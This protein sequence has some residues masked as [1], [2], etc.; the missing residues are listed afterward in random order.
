[1]NISES[2]ELGGGETVTFVG[3]G[4][5]TSTM[6]RLASEFSFFGLSIV[7]TTTKIFEWEGKKADF[8]LI[9]EDIE[10][11]EN[12][13]SALSE[14]KIVTIASGKSKDEKLIGVEPEFADEINAQISPDILV[15]EGDGASKKSFKAPAD[16]EPVIPASSDLIVPIVGIDVVGETLNSE[17]VHRPKKV[18][19]ISHFEIGDTVTPE[20]IGQVVGHEKGGRKNVPS[21]ASLIPLL[22]KVDDESKEIAEEVAKKILSYTRQI[23]KVALGC[24]IRENPIIKIIER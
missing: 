23:D 9:S 15:I 21:D 18:C 19:E 14:G 5:K 17:N 3:A 7:T 20:M 13:I 10:D 12:L 24:I 1:M 2:F 22:N 4:G 8:L 6:F 11:L 16:Y